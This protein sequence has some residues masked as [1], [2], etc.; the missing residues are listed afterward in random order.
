MLLIVI[1]RLA[2]D[3]LSDRIAS[4]LS[5]RK[6]RIILLQFSYLAHLE[7]PRCH[8]LYLADEAVHLC[9]C[10]SPV[11]VRYD[12]DAVQH[13]LTKD[14]LQ[15]REPSLWRYHELLPVRAPEH[16]I[17]LGEGMT[18]LIPMKRIGSTVGLKHLFV[19]DEGVI[20]TGSF[21]ARGA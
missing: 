17:S 2:P 13:A 18:P 5:S 6:E 4:I 16:I 21:K 10:G 7:C 19:K 8:T 3:P 12:L 20:P 9:T 11:L 15:S 14:L 1:K